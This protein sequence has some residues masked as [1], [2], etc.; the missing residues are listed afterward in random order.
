M[1]GALRVGLGLRLLACAVTSALVLGSPLAHADEECPLGSVM[2]SDNGQTWCEPTVCEAD[3]QCP[4]GSLCRPVSLCVEVGVLEQR[5][6][7]N[8]DAGQKLMVRQRCGADKSCPQRTTCSE[9]SRCITRAQAD[10]AGLLTP[11]G[12][13]SATAGTP[14]TP[15]APKKSC[16]CSVPGTA[17]GEHA[18]AVLALLGLVTVAARRRSVVAGRKRVRQR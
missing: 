2:K 1:L 12:A 8:D 18:G 15:E 7:V 10:K 4:T 5:P 17:G 16:G 14:A 9:K 11:A 3:S 13:A 6:G